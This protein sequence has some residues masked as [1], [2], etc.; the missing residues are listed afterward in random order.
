MLPDWDGS[1]ADNFGVPADD[2]DGMMILVDAEGYPRAQ[3]RG[4]QAGQ[5]I[6]AA[7]G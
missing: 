1:V 5:Q 2:R 6:L 3:G 4:T 7:I